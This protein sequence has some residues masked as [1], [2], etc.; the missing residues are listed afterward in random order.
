MTAPTLIATS[1]EP[2]D[3]SSSI[4]G[5]DLNV[6]AFELER[7]F[8]V[9]VSP[10]QFS[11]MAMRNDPPDIRVGELFDFIRPAGRT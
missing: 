1:R 10:D 7:R 8:G 6:V 5:I 2:T 3:Q 11:K 4:M 9:R